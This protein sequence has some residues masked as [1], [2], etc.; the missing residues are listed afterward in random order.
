MNY[1][2]TSG[3]SGIGI[4][5]YEIGG[6]RQLSWDAATAWANTLVYG[7]FSDWRLPTRNPSDTSCAGGFGVGI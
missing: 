5:M 3:H 1:A 4:G 7:G 6:M 2:L